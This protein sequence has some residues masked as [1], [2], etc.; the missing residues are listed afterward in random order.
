MRDWSVLGGPRVKGRSHR[1]QKRMRPRTAWIGIVAAIVAFVGPAVGASADVLGGHHAWLGADRFGSPSARAVDSTGMG[2]SLG[3]GGSPGYPAANPNTRTLYVPL[4]CRNPSTGATCAD[5]AQHV[6]DVISTSQCNATATSHCR[7]I[8]QATV[9]R[10]ANEVVIDEQTDTIYV[11][12]GVNDSGTFSVL[13]GAR[14]NATVTIGCGKPLATIKLGGF[15]AAAA[16]DP[17]TG[18]LYV[19]SPTGKVFVIDAAG[20][21]AR[22]TNGCGHPVKVVKDP[23]GPDGIAVDVATDTV[24][25]ANSGATGDGHTVSVIN[26][27][28]CNASNGGGCDQTPRLINVGINP[29]WVAV[30]QATDTAYVANYNDGTVSVIN[31]ATCNAKVISGC[32]ETPP[33]VS[34]GNGIAFLG[35]DASRHTLFALNQ[36]DD[37]M[38]AINTKT[39]D[40]TVTSGCPKLA[41]DQGLPF[42]PPHGENPNG[43]AFVPQT[44]TAYLVNVGGEDFLKPVRISGCSAIETSACR[45]E[46]PTVP[47]PEFFPVVDAATH[48]IY[49]GNTFLPQVDVFNTATCNAGELSGCAPVAEIPMPDPQA[50]LDAIDEITHTLYASDPFGNTIS[51]I[52][53]ATCNATNTTGCTAATPK[54][55]TG[56][57]P[58]APVLDTLTHTLYAEYEA[59]ASRVAVINAATCNAQD[60]TGCGQ[61]PASVA[62]AAGAFLIA[63]SQATNTIYAPNFFGDA[64]SVINGATCD[65]SD[66]SGCGHLA[67]KVRVLPSS[68]GI[69][70]NDATHTV[71]VANGANGQSPGTVSIINSNTCNGADTKQCAR[72]WPTVPVG[73]G[74]FFVAVDSSTG[75]VYISD[76]QAATV[77][78]IDGNTCNSETTKDCPNP[79]PT[80]ATAG[81]PDTLAIDEQT[82]TVYAT[83]NVGFLPNGI[84]NMS[85]FRGAP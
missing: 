25:A 12:G 36:Q 73:R 57:F 33:A 37:T 16:L 27:A 19:A 11:G 70:V 63:L 18:T 71:Y 69:A 17:A 78:I 21:N 28:T 29:F 84:H 64:V 3:L 72:S 14:C 49:A 8:A 74:P 82:N 77:S 40:A 44:G 22:T 24:Y 52:N 62:V 79:A 51:V 45:V 2:G 41:P 80:V 56:S 75:A 20:C 81:S 50:N 1:P 53:T 6:V 85:I 60:T 30:D 59:N 7:V 66:H 15:P 65:A 46:A 9:G 67:A 48:T 10:N 55:T 35:V 42:N 32:G 13:N 47:E 4:Q 54:I 23:R 76:S 68:T 58:G 43:F 39:C 5:T 61:H 83:T 26:G 31:G 34:T 38:S